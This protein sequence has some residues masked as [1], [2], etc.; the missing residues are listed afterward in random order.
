MGN[1]HSPLFCALQFSRLSH[2][3]VSSLSREYFHEIQSLILLT[4]YK[5][6]WKISDNLDDL[7][8]FIHLDPQTNDV[9]NNI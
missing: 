5:S 1:K 9:R 3:L 6:K 4:I 8:H 2:K 7:S